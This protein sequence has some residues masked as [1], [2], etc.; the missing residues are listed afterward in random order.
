ML[1]TR[2][3]S[4]P[5]SSSEILTSYVVAM[6]QKNR[7]NNLRTIV[8]IVATGRVKAKLGTLTTRPII[9]ASRCQ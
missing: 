3:E 9:A 1:C 2:G 6:S 7:Y 4:G 5:L 8:N